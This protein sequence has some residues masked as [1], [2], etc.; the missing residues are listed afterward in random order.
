[1]EVLVLFKALNFPNKFV[2]VKFVAIVVKL[3][4]YKEVLEELLVVRLVV[5]NSKVYNYLREK[6][7]SLCKTL[8]DVVC[9]LLIFL[10][11]VFYMN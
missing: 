1:M 8:N 6:I 11:S 9:K 3:R 4:I 7:L 2:I 5:L 10:H